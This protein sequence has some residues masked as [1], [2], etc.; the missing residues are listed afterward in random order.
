MFT[1]FN[2]D[3]NR[4]IEELLSDTVSAQDLEKIEKVYMKELTEKKFV[5][6]K[7]QFEYAWC[8]VRSKYGAD[9]NN[10]IKNF[11]SLCKDDPENKRDYIYYI[12]I[13]YIRLK[14]LP[15]AQK[16]VK[17]FLEIEPNNHQV[18]LLDEHIETEMR[19]EFKRDAAVAGGAL[20][21]F[22]GLLG[23]G[24]A[25]AKKHYDKKKQEKEEM[26]PSSD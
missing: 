13:G 6:A 5:S 21:V 3:K 20:L 10:G 26:K 4:D 16:Y 17:A 12:A 14:D 25:L 7:T 23:V 22:G 11:E 19:K 8:L 24:F 2:T 1:S 9:I 18:I 15:T